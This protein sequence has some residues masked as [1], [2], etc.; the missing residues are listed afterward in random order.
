MVCKDRSRITRPGLAAPVAAGLM[1]LG[2]CAR[3]QSTFSVFGIEAEATRSL[4]LTMSVAA[5]LIAIGVLWV[6]FHAARSGSTSPRMRP[7]R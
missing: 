4:T 6:A 1:L 3:E 5:A 2:G 7:C